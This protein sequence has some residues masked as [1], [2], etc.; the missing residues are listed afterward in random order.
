VDHGRIIATRNLTVPGNG[1]R[2]WQAGKREQSPSWLRLPIEEMI[3]TT[4]KLAN[5]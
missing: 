1:D 3:S 4:A 2:R 5:Q